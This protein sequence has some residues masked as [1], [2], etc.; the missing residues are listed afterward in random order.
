[1][2]FA[3]QRQIM[4]QTQLIRR[5]ITD[6][7]VLAA[8]GKVPR[9]KFVPI[10]LQK[11]AYEDC[12][13]SI[14]E[15]QTISQ[16]YMVAIMTQCLELHGT[17]KI[18][19]IG[20]GS[21]YQTAI[22]AE[23]AQSVISIE[24]IATLADQARARLAELGYTNITVICADGTLG[25]PAEQPYA[26]IIVTA[27]APKIPQTL[28]DQLQ[29]GGKLVI[30]VGNRFSQTLTVVEKKVKGY[31]TRTVCGCVFVPLLGQEGWHLEAE[32]LDD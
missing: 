17:E 26:G 19:E 11:S 9:E 10:E 13:L 22:L 4:V 1:M 21:G 2:N 7:R 23:L 29:P 18:L 24:R 25:Y 8:M 3:Q 16:P 14:G 15:G 12:P 20:T 31:K 27:G 32:N 6:T 5:G 28:I 30:P